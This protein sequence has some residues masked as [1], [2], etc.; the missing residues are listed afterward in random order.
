MLRKV[1]Y[2]YLFLAV[3]IPTGKL[4][5]QGAE[6][7]LFLIDT[8]Q[9]KGELLFVGDSSILLSMNQG[10]SDNL[11]ASKNSPIVVE[12]NREI[13]AVQVSGKSYIL[14]GAGIGLLAGIASGGSIGLASGNDPPGFLSMTA[15][16]KAAIGGVLLGGVGLIVGTIAGI[17]SSTN[18]A[19]VGPLPGNDFSA[20]K[21]YARYPAQ[22]PIFLKSFQ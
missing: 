7:I 17:A 8:R 21:S 19:K 1:L 11:L 5:S 4:I 13:V 2:A 10:L 6:V 12:K 18:D 14:R 15:G 16:D 22:E 3:C 20:L 9:I